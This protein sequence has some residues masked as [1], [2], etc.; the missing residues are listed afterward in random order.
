MANGNPN[1]G[2]NLNGK[3]IFAK[4]TTN[5]WPVTG[6]AFSIPGYIPA[7]CIFEIPR[8]TLE[9]NIL[10][11][12]QNFSKD[13][14][15]VR[16]E[17]NPNSH[18]ISL[19]AWITKDSRDITDHNFS[20]RDD[21]IITSSIMKLSDRMRIL[22]NMYGVR[23][24]K[25]KNIH[26]DPS[27][28]DNIQRKFNFVKPTNGDPRFI[29]TQLDIIAVMRSIMDA[30]DEIY[31]K[32]YDRIY[33]NADPADKKKKTYPQQSYGISITPRIDSHGNCRSFVITKEKKEAKG[34]DNLHP[35]TA[36][37]LSNE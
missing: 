8:E 21:L 26:G 30:N 29:G 34:A 3:E 15:Y 37:R 4:D 36:Q 17:I 33:Q 19:W 6:T 10:E 1:Q 12:L 11:I 14:V 7:K 27:S 24:E 18:Q 35:K 23:T 32:L 5:L 20:N 22:R 28:E 13:F 31:K 2:Q 16:F 9:N 25:S